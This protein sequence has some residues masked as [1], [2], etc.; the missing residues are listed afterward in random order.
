MRNHDDQPD[1]DRVVSGYCATINYLEGIRLVATLL[2]GARLG[3]SIVAP[4]EWGSSVATVGA[5]TRHA[6]P[7]PGPHRRSDG[8]ER[9]SFVTPILNR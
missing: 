1:D 2:R 3:V 8:R 5:P 7:A 4:R 9:E 6:A